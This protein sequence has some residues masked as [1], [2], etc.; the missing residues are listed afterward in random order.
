RVVKR[1]FLRLFGCC[2][3]CRIESADYAAVYGDVCSQGPRAEKNSACAA[4]R[5]HSALCSECSAGVPARR[6]KLQAR[7]GLSRHG[8]TFA[9]AEFGGLPESTRADGKMG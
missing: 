3:A 1:G 4:R 5:A 8:E 2:T 6:R 9:M 7:I